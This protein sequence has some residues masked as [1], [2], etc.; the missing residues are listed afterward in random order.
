MQTISCLIKHHASKTY[1]R[2]GGITPH[3]FNFLTLSSNFT[4]RPLYSREKRP[5]YPLDKRL[6]GPQN[7][8]E[9]G[10]EEKNFHLAPA[11]N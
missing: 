10:G 3:I 6:D 4:P 2:S 5:W 11:E 7:W 1:W 9:R 8:S